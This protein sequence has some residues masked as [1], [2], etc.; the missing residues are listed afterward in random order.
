MKKHFFLVVIILLATCTLWAQEDPPIMQE[1]MRCG[2]LAELEKIK[3]IETLQMDE[4]T[5]LRFFS[6]RSEHMRGQK[7]LMDS[8]KELLKELEKKIQ[9]E[10]IISAD[11]YDTYFDKLTHSAKQMLTNKLEF[12]GSLSDILTSEQIAKLVVFEFSFMREIRKIMRKERRRR[13]YE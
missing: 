1:G 7:N 8:R 2:K 4:E 10:E 5:T 9:N 6:R 11:D 3:L 12:Y 13:D